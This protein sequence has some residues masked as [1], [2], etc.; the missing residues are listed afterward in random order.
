[1]TKEKSLSRKDLGKLDKKTKYLFSL[2]QNFPHPYIGLDL[3]YIK[4]YYRYRHGYR[5]MKLRQ[6]ELEIEALRAK[7]LSDV[8]FGSETYETNRFMQGVESAFIQIAYR[9]R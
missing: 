1:M 5:T 6:I 9:I 3:G 4:G 2:L 7:R 8:S